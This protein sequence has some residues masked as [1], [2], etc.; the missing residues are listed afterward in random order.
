MKEE[1]SGFDGVRLPRYLEEAVGVEEKIEKDRSLFDRLRHPAYSLKGFLRYHPKFKARLILAIPLAVL[2]A[3]SVDMVYI[4]PQ[5][6]K[7]RSITALQCPQPSENEIQRAFGIVAANR[8]TYYDPNN[9]GSLPN[10]S[11]SYRQGLTEGNRLLAQSLDTLDNS[12]RCNDFVKSEIDR[13]FGEREMLEGGA[14]V[15]GLVSFSIIW[16]N[17]RFRSRGNKIK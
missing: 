14:V 6:D 17:S 12:R 4:Q 1:S 15:A 13:Q 7:I 16:L 5:I 11:P 8:L 10:W 3:G 9:P 2:T